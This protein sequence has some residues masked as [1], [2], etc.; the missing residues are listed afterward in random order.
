MASKRDYYEVLGISKDASES[1]I[2]KA[3]RNLAK[4][5]HPDVSKEP[6]A[7]EKFVEIN[8][9]YQILSDPEKKQ[10]YDQFGHAGVDPNQ[11]FG[12]GGFS[13]GY[14]GFEDIFDSFF[15]GGFSGQ[16]R[17]QANTSPRKG[18]DRFMQMNIDFMDAVFGKVNTINLNVDEQCSHCHG[19]GAETPQDI[20]TCS[21]CNGTGRTVT[22]QRTMFGVF[23]SET[24]CSTCNGTGKQV[25]RACHLC[26]GDGYQNKRVAV[27]VNIP[28][29]IQTG[30]QLRV[31][32][33]GERGSNGGP[34][35]DLYIEIAVKS[36]PN[37]KRD[38]DNI[39]I[40][41]P[42]SV[43][44]ATLGTKKEVPTVHGDVELTIPEGTQYGSKFRL[45]GKG[46][47]NI[48]TNKMGDQIVEV[49]VKIDDSLSKEERK[50]YEQLQ[51]VTKTEESVFDKFKRAFK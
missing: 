26:H 5:Y 45:K 50:L 40:K 35:G 21:T 4:K 49:D 31:A 2:K 30:Q 28:A 15:G 42:I 10:A 34:N 18:Q 24:T 3:Y 47:N 44:E 19:S 32:G 6:D 43:I 38:G 14:G 13:G 25:K 20:Q 9:A 23:Q 29:G 27:D 7:Q 41:I 1:E 39:Y 22:Q 48:R 17:Q 11:G 33:K 8:E 37:F 16:T 12:Q 36:H 51:N 46:V